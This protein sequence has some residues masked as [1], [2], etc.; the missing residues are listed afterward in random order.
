M[1]LSDE[2]FE[3]RFTAIDCIG[4]MW[5]AVTVHDA[6]HRQEISCTTQYAVDHGGTPAVQVRSPHLGRAG[7][8]LAKVDGIMAIVSDDADGG[9]L[10]V[11]ETPEHHKLALQLHRNPAH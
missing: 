10:C 3:P 8:I 1:V 4:A 2:F 9:Y 7:L 6:L 5:L 11:H